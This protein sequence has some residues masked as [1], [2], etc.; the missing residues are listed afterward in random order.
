M[1][2]IEILVSFLAS[3]TL[4]SLGACVKLVFKLIDTTT[5]LKQLKATTDSILKHVIEIYSRT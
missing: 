2:I 5:E 1:E 3:V 4:L